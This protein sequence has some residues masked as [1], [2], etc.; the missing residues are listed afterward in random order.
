MKF[1]DFEAILSSQRLRRYLLACDNNT[2]KA[3]TLYRYNLQVSQEMFTLVSCF[4]VALRNAINSKLLVTLGEDWLRDASLNGGIFDDPN[5]V[6][7]RDI[8]HNAYRKLMSSRIYSH[9]KLL[10]EMEFGIWKYMY[11]PRQFY[12]TGQVLLSIFPNKPRSSREIQYNQRYFFNALDRVNSLRNRIAHH[13]PI[14]F[15]TRQ[16]IIDTSYIES[17]YSLVHELFLWMGVES[18]SLLYGL[19]HVEQVCAKIDSL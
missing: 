5:M 9:D 12:A 16:S 10:A 17:I 13:E 6:K 8:I 14:C 3:M 7:T 11:S 4:E 19:D 1:S 18:H 15:P 2:R